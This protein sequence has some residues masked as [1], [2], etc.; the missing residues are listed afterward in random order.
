[1]FVKSE[2]SL[3]ASMAK[4]MRLGLAAL[5]L[6]IAA[7]GCKQSNIPNTDV[8]DNQ[9]N[10]DVV[11]FVER[12]RRA[13]EKRDVGALISLA[14]PKYYDDNGTPSG[15]DDLDFHRLQEHLTQWREAILDVR[16]EMRYRRVS[17]EKGKILVDYTYTASFR[18]SAPEGERWARRVADNRLTLV[19]N[20]ASKSFF[21]LSGM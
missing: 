16:Y 2:Q 15:K 11:Y 9:P 10:R 20:H 3:A 19:R 18:I 21:I 14:S 7:S 6:G 4:G 12:Y 1:M 5:I 17:F 8:P 13:V